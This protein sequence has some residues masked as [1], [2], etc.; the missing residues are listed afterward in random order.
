MSGTNL[1]QTIPNTDIT[2][3]NS[4][5]SGYITSLNTAKDIQSN[6]LAR[7]NDVK[8]ILDSETKRLITKKT[9]IDNAMKAQGRIIF[10]NDNSR[11]RYAAY[12]KIIIAI[13]IVLATLFVLKL[14]GDNFSDYVPLILIQLFYVISISGGIIYVW[15]TY[16]EILRHSRYNYDE[17][18]LDPPDASMIDLS[19]NTA[20]GYGNFGLG[21]LGLKG[22]FCVDGDCC[23]EGTIWNETAGK[24]VVPS[25]TTAPPVKQGFTTRSVMPADVSEYS[26]YGVYK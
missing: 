11:K 25:S 18:R 2:P 24:C 21:T 26:E 15:A 9:E 13:V 7:Q 22:D 6:A 3:I 20:S 23:D 4:N 1:P 8:N 19:G 12:L 14:V 16:S 17:M 10:F 5:L